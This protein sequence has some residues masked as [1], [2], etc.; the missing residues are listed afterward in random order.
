M[1]QDCEET[2]H[3]LET[4]TPESKEVD[5]PTSSSSEDENEKSTSEACEQPAVP[6]NVTVTVVE[7]TGS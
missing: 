6:E 3:L 7:F 4:P 5:K 1:A 2:N